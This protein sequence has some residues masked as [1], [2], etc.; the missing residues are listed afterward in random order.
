M[1]FVVVVAT[2]LVV[3]NELRHARSDIRVGTTRPRAARAAQPALTVGLTQLVVFDAAARLIPQGDRYRVVTGSGAGTDDPQVLR[4]VKP[5]ARY[6][7][8]PRRLVG[9]DGD[10][11]WILSYGARINRLGLRYER[12]FPV[13]SGL[14]VAKVAVTP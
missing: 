6:T 4:W 9:V 5:Y 12:V 7:L 8:L 3:P 13:G 11:Q 10:P 2:V 14:S 1:I